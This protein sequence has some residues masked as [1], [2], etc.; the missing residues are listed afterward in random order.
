MNSSTNCSA[1][2]TSSNSYSKTKESNSSEKKESSNCEKRETNSSSSNKN[3]SSST[4]SSSNKN[5]KQIHLQNNHT[6]PIFSKLSEILSFYSDVIKEFED[7]LSTLKNERKEMKIKYI[8][9][10]LNMKHKLNTE[11]NIKRQMLKKMIINNGQ[12]IDNLKMKLQTNKDK[13]IQYLNEIKL[14]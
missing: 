6:N 5:T 13:I 1:S 11:D 2:E 3:T 12:E 7:E 10:Y 8:N 9:K 14:Q 4:E